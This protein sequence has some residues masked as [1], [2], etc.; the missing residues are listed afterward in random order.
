MS[1]DIWLEIDTGGPEPAVVGSD[2][3]NYTS[4]CAEMWREA[5]ANLADFHGQ[6]AVEC[7]PTLRTAIQ[8]MEADPARFE[9]M[10]PENGWGSYATLVPRL[11]VLLEEFEAHPRA[12]VTVSR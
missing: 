1:Y 6:P 4:N 8:T 2:S 5:G 9:A 12:I 11:R 3:W 7:I 10:N